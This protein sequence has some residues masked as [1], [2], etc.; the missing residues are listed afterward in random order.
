MNKVAWIAVM[1]P[2][3]F[4]AYAEKADLKRAKRTVPKTKWE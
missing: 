2:L 1:L 4:G 3:S